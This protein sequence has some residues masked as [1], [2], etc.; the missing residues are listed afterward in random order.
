MPRNPTTPHRH[1]ELPVVGKLE[2]VAT[3]R[4]FQLFKTR[5]A[6]LGLGPRPVHGFQKGVPILGRATGLS[7][8]RGGLEELD[9]ETIPA[10]VWALAHGETVAGQELAE[11]S[12]DA[13]QAALQDPEDIVKALECVLELVREATGADDEDEDEEEGGD[14]DRNQDE[15]PTT[16]GSTTKT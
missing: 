14:S 8:L 10:L 13:L 12:H 9:E 4:A 15:D 7:I 16:E 2:L 6:E 5:T 11:P 3:L 1:L